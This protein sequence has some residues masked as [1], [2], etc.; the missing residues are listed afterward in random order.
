MWFDSHHYI[1]NYKVFMKI[2]DLIKG[3]LYQPEFEKENCGF[4]M[5][6]NLEETPSH[7]LLKSSIVALTRLSHRG[8]RSADGL[9]GDGCGLL[10]SMPMDFFKVVATTQ[11]ISLDEDFAVGNVFLNNDPALQL[12]TKSC[13]VKILAEF[14]LIV[15][16]WRELPLNHKYL[17]NQAA[18]CCPIIEQIFINKP[19][20]MTIDKFERLL[21]VARKK[22]EQALQND[23]IFYVVSLS[24]KVIGYK[25][26][27]VPEHL[28][29]FYLDLCDDRVKT[30]LCLFHQR[31]STN[32]LPE[33]RLAQPF[34][35]L[36]HNGEIN[37]V[38]GNRNWINAKNERLCSDK[39]LPHA[40]SIMPVVSGSDSDSCSLDNVLELL[41]LNGMELFRAMRIMIPPAWQNSEDMDPD[42][43]AFYEY[44]AMHMGAW[45]GPAGVVTTDGRYGVCALD[46]NGLRPVR[47]VTTVDG[48]I[49]LASEIGVYDYLPEEVIAKGAS[50]AWGNFSN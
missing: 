24:S 14:N 20:D 23:Q 41:H 7:K 37:T 12:A 4:G 16:G 17:G 21:F 42:L 3:G 30:T 18:A 48:N 13:M 8:A 5:I 45:D 6:A 10:F 9:S 33:W 25:G 50:R 47:W 11:D 26:L 32:T 46:R 15:A 34:R 40:N 1:D 2:A 38:K 28:S 29:D 31:F 19:L 22:C 36:A 35:F 44:H 49:T 43:K 39:L 27:V